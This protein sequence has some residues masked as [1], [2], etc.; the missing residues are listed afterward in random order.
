[1]N[2][3]FTGELRRVVYD[4][5]VKL[6][7]SQWGRFTLEL[8]VDEPRVFSTF[9]LYFRSG[10]GWYAATGTLPGKRWGT[11]H[12]PRSAFRI[13]GN[14]AGWD[15]IDGIR[16]SAWRGGSFTGTCLVDNLVAHRR[17]SP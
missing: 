11:V 2:A 16:L 12:F 17:L 15:K 13:E 10:S 8:R 5:D 9:T 14:P 7:L 1:M 6:D 3:D 4:K